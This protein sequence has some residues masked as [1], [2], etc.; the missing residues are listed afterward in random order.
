MRSTILAAILALSATMASAQDKMMEEM[1][2][3]LTMV[4]T[5]AALVLKQYGIEADVMTLSLSQIAEIN[6]VLTGSNS[7]A[8]KKA[9]IEAALRM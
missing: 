2:A 6:G 4:E 8:D 3:G 1:S 7:D 9:G 5:S